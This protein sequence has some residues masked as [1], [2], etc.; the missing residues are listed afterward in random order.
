M[1]WRARLSATL[2]LARLIS[3]SRYAQ[4]SVVNFLLLLER[5]ATFNIL[6]VAP[7]DDAIFADYLVCSPASVEALVLVYELWISRFQDINFAEKPALLKIVKKHGG[8]R[9][10]I[11]LC[12]Y[13]RFW[14]T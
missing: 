2:A 12:S 7:I 14:R 8:V 10:V 6:T 11:E 13:S 1:G 9:P 4:F 3:S 5:E